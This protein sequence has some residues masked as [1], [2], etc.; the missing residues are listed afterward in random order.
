MTAYLAFGMMAL[1]VVVG[2]FAGWVIAEV[3]LFTDARVYV[4]ACAVTVF[5]LGLLVSIVE[6]ATDTVRRM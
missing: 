4:L 5:T 6:S 3:G 2:V 1:S